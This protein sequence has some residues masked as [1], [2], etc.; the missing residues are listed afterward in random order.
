MPDAIPELKILPVIFGFMIFLGLLTAATGSK[1]LLYAW[2]VL[3]V[4]IGVASLVDFWWWEYD[5]GH[6]LNPHAP[7]KIPGMAHL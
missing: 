7:I 3:I 5:Y 6:N 4:L 2:A 1:K